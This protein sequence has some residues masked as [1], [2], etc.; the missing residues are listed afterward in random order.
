[1]NADNRPGDRKEG[2]RRKQDALASAG[3]RGETIVE[4][5]R[6]VLLLRLLENPTATADDVR[7]SLDLPEGLDARCLGA[8]PIGLA[9]AGIIQ[10][11]GYV[12]SARPERHAGPIQVWTL[13]DRAA[14][15]AW[16]AAHPEAA[17]TVP[18]SQL[19]LFE[20]A[21]PRHDRRPGP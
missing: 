19:P 13:A 9:R 8:V 18:G 1:M 17:A 4:R 21:N 12:R 3:P 20:A 5:G 10:S 16:L 11:A 15:M 7:Q 2:E 14:A 6:R